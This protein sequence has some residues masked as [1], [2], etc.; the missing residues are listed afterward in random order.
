MT[1]NGQTSLQN[2]SE[3]TK[4]RFNIS[5]DKIITADLISIPLSKLKL[6]PKNVRFKHIEELMTDQQLEETIW[7]ESD[8]KSLLKEIRYSQGLSEQP[9]VKKISDSEYVVKEGNRRT[10][11]LR[12][13]KA[14]IASRKEENIPIEKIDAVQCIVLPEDVD[15]PAIALYL[16]RIHV[17]GKKPWSAANQG[18]HV[19]DLVKKFS[20]DWSEIAKSIN[21]SKNT[22]NQMVKAYDATMEYH[23][24][25]PDQRWLHRYSHFLELYKRRGLKDWADEPKNLEQFRKWIF[26]GKIPMAIQVR[27][28]EK[29][30]LEDRNA[31]QAMQNGATILEAEE[32]MK[33]SKKA[34]LAATSEDVDLQVQNFVQ[35]MRNI[36][37]NKMHEIS[38]DKE[39]LQKME[40]LHEEF[41]RLLGDIKKLD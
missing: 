30:I 6:D 25:Y 4:M 15:D 20:Y 40:S 29:I 19:Y 26:D 3:P 5:E 35:F 2:T 17:S 18:A 14:E 1:M 12:K 11:C 27:K 41:G 36:P 8:T 13:L 28:L 21:V 37:R 31:Y 33:E 34:K 24:K 38:K 39:Q 22:I 23:E 7:K 16:A 10:V 9:L 32:K